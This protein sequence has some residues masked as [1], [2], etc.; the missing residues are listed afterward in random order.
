MTSSAPFIHIENVSKLYGTIRALHRATIKVDEGEFIA[1]IGPSGAGKSTLMRLLIREELPSE[2]HIFVA[3]R[4][5]TKL[6]VSQLP[7]YRRRLGMVFQDYKLLPHK[8]VFENVAFPLEVS[9]APDAIIT[10]TVT[11][12][13]TLV[14]L[15]H[16]MAAFPKE[17]SGGEAQRASI[18][19]A[20]VHSPKILLADEPTGN[21]DPENAKDI[22]ELLL[23]INKTGTIVI[24]ATHNQAIIERLRKRVVVLKSGEVVFD[25]RS[26]Q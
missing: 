17:L 8:T 2:G 16:R 26:P 13:L 22:I 3:S 6:K 19:R 4:D 21:L 12:I 7:Y 15:D 5:I 24:L 14:G 9:G 11:K 1:L 20:L 10:P 23:K 25:Q 18:A